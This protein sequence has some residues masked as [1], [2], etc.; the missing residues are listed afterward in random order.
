MYV[1]I[2]LI[3]LYSFILH[4]YNEHAFSVLLNVTQCRY[5]VSIIINH[6]GLFMCKRENLSY[7]MRSIHFHPVRERFFVYENQ[8]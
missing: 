1:L 3:L 4:N 6:F 5:L 8:L 7:L 2:S